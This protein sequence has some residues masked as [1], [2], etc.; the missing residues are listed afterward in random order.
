MSEGDIYWLQS[1]Q[2][3]FRNKQQASYYFTCTLP[4]QDMLVAV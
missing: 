1:S 3:G 4:I 2:K